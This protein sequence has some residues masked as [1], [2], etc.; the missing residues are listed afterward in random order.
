MIKTRMSLSQKSLLL[1]F[2]NIFPFVSL[3]NISNKKLHCQATDFYA[4][5]KI[6]FSSTYKPAKT[7]LDDDAYLERKG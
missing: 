2:S 1:E 7:R 3:T 5:L 6:G 4:S